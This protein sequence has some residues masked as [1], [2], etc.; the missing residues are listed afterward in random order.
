[1]PTD[2]LPT[3]GQLAVIDISSE[4]KSFAYTVNVSVIK[5]IVDF[6]SDRNFDREVVSFYILSSF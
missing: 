6:D 5:A 4:L 1:L 2:V 3:D